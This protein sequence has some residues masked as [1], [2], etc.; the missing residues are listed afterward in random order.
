MPEIHE[1]G[2]LFA[3][4]TA[5]GI[6]NVMAGGGS[7]LTLP[8]L[9]FL[10]LD[11]VTANGTNRIAIVLQNVSASASFRNE[12][13]SRLR[14][15][16][17]FAVL[18]LP[19]SIVGA[20]VA[21]NIGNEWFE[22]ILAIVIVGVVISMLLPRRNHSE[23]SPDGRKS[24]WVYPA[25][26]GIGFYGGFIQVGVGFLLMATLYHLLRMDL[27][28][29]NMHKVM[30]VLLY[31]LPALAVFVF[32]GHVNWVLGLCLAAGNA[33]GAW[34]AARISVRRGEK[35]IRGVLVVALLLMAA[36]LIGAF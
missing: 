3:A 1:I 35:V 21:V 6:I 23:T 9:I 24:F 19:G 17:V 10:G 11:A 5:A 32:T 26:F 30:I 16:A 13:I 14:E 25:L 12:K 7:A 33:L 22:R 29:V 27:V 34:W 2:L 20:V 36:K 28:F 4:G 31:T 18:A 15:S 8:I